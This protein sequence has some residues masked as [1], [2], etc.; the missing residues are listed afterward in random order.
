MDAHKDCILSKGYYAV[1]GGYMLLRGV[2][3]CS[4]GLYEEGNKNDFSGH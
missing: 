2:T 3:S 1:Q 4:V